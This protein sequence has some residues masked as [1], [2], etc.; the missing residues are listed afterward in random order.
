MYARAKTQKKSKENRTVKVLIQLFSLWFALTASAAGSDCADCATV[1]RKT[2]TNA[3]FLQA[4]RSWAQPGCWQI[5]RQQAE[6]GAKE[7][8]E[9][10]S[11]LGSAVDASTNPDPLLDQSLAAFS[12]ATTATCD[13]AGHFA[14][15]KADPGLKKDKIQP[16]LQTLETMP[17]F[18]DTREKISSS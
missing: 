5:T 16:L 12:P 2:E 9:G 13:D 15:L 10:L 8:F 1:E 3:S 11:D 7:L 17:S 6:A 14:F 18:L 4:I